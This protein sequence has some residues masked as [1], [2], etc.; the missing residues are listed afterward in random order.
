MLKL[1][2]YLENGVPK[3]H[4]RDADMVKVV[5]DDACEQ[6]GVCLPHR[7]RV[8]QK[9]HERRPK[10]SAFGPTLSAN[11]VLL[12]PRACRARSNISLNKIE[13]GLPLRPFLGQSTR[14]RDLVLG[15]PEPKPT[16]LGKDPSPP[17]DCGFWR[18]HSGIRDFLAHP[19]SGE[20]I[21][22]FQG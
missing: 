3:D 1:E 21:K 20:S 14:S 18:Q 5:D 8:A 4:K 17:T 13:V 9:R 16:S 6:V 15:Y 7:E 12:E 2:K 10:T 11:F 22:K 19:L